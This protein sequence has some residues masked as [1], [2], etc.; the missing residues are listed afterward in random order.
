MT[1]GPWG[2]NT[3]PLIELGPPGVVVKRLTLLIGAVYFTFVAVTNF[4]AVLGGDHWTVRNSGNAADIESITKAHSF[5]HAAVALAVVAETIG[6]VLLWRAVVRYGGNGT[7]VRE[8]WW[9]LTGNVLVW[10]GFIAGTESFVADTSESPFRELLMIGLAMAVV[11]TVVPDDPGSR[12][13]S[14]PSEP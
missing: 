3:S 4:V 10:L 5:D 14:T 13:G 8:A 9:A 2:G 7:G 6:A 12:P 1:T 11:I